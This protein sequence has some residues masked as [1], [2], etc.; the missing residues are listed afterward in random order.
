MADGGVKVSFFIPIGALLLSI[1]IIISLGMVF[2]AI[3]LAVSTYARSFKEAQTYLS[4]LIILAMVPGYATMM[5][6]P[7]DLQ[8]F[9]FFVPLLNAIA[10]LKMSLGGVINYTYLTMGWNIL[11]LCYSFADGC[12]LD[13]QQGKGFVPK[14]I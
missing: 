7:D 11:D 6:Q 13:V 3:Q 2:A 10:S 5:M 1:L 14:L 9:M 4:F 8:L 12:S